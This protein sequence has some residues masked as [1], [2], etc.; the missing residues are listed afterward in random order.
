MRDQTLDVL[1]EHVG[2]EI[3]LVPRTELG[4]RRR[5]ERV[6]DECDREGVV[7]ELGDR[8]RDPVDRDRALFDAVPQDSGR[9]LDEDA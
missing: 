3:H 8:E 2:F 6:R 1:R 4:E 5:R 7:A 9:R